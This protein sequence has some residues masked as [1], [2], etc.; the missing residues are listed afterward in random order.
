MITLI[1]CRLTP[2]V[3]KDDYQ[4]VL[5]L[6]EIGYA[7]GD[8]QQHVTQDLTLPTEVT[9]DIAYDAI[10]WISNN[11]AIVSATGVV[12]RLNEDIEVMLVASVTIGGQSKENVITVIVKADSTLPTMFTVTFDSN[13]GTAVNNQVVAAGETLTAPTNPIR[14][15]YTFVAWQFNGVNFDFT[16]AVNSNLNLTALWQAIPTGV[17]FQVAFNSNGGSTVL[18]QTVN[19]SDVLTAPAVP[20]RGT[21]AF[22]GWYK[23]FE[24]TEAWNFVSDTVT[25]DITLYAL[26]NLADVPLHSGRTLTFQDEFDG[27]ALDLDKWDYQN[28]TGSQFGLHNWGNN[29]QQY[30][31]TEN[32]VVS[33]GTLK[34]N[35]KME[36]YGNRNYTSGKIVTLGRHGQTFG[37]IE[38]RLKA[39]IGQGFW[40]AFWMMPVNNTYGSGWPFNGEIDIMEL[41]GRLPTQVTSAIHYQA[42]WNQHHYL[43]GQTTIPGGGTIDQF[44]V[45]AVEWIEGRLEFSVDGHVYHVRQNDWFASNNPAPFDHDFFIILNLAIGGH[46]DGHLLPEAEHFPAA[47]EV[48]YVRAYA[49]L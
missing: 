25:A 48:D 29:E 49:G 3:V 19:H 26:W 10:S 46:F 15:G 32:V 23:D 20:T 7:P 4:K 21:D 5:E 47:L 30:Y 9:T 14:L 22:I 28:G 17:T 2:N 37:R 1:G 41:R 44:H 39:P 12:N 33:N 8:S 27:D 6:I 11:P 18:T 34:I 43:H 38:A 16:W 31:R 35:A 36:N 45:Y 40:P 13:G 42:T 24:L